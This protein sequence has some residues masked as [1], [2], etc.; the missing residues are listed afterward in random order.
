MKTVRIGVIG[1]GWWATTA[2]IPAIQSH[3]GAELIAVQSRERA[4]AERIAR[5]FGAKH[6][7]TSVEELLALQEVDAVIIASTPNVHYAQARAALNSGRHVLLEKPMTLTTDE[8]RELVELAAKKK[9]QLLMSCPWH[10]TRHGIEARRL[11]QSGALGEIKMISV[12]MTNPIDKLLRGINTSPTHGMEKV[13]VEPRKGSYS[14]PAVAG[15]GQIY[16]QVS[17]AAAYLTFLTGLRPA[18]VFARFDR[19]GSPN[20][21]YNTL[22]ITLENGA[23]VSLASTG[24]TPLAER[25]YEVRIFGNKGILQ[26]ELWRG[27]MTM[28]DF[29]D[30]RTEFKPL[31]KDEVYPSRSPAL[32]FIDTILGRAVNGSP[33]EFGL[34]SMEIIEAAC[35]SAQTGR[36]E[37][38]RDRQILVENKSVKPAVRKIST[39]TAAA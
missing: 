20:D 6:T 13:Y 33:G 22:A 9:L 1:A 11:I 26:L 35:E 38:I 36:N 18:E 29:N 30:K 2:H 8:A 32:N 17:H 4:K 31:A 39:P 3:R 19:D 24:A 28:I 16:C 7:F 14:D 10:Y 37:K 12:L 27:T 23:L 15:G 5:D 21:I 34:A 25:N